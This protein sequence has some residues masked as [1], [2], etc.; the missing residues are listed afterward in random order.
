MLTGFGLA[1]G[2]PAPSP[3]LQR[4]VDHNRDLVERAQR[5]ALGGC[6]CDGTS[7]ARALRR[8]VWRRRMRDAGRRLPPDD[9]EIAPGWNYIGAF[10]RTKNW[11]EKWTVFGPESVFDLRER[12][13]DGN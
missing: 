12:A 6:E 5:L 2:G 7:P 11:L 10:D 3:A 8:T 1:V 4:G 13:E 9:R